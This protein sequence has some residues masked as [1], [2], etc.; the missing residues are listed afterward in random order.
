MDVLG[1]IVNRR[2]ALWD[3]WSCRAFFVPGYVGPVCVRENIG[4][5]VGVLVRGKWDR[6][7]DGTCEC[8]T[9]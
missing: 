4:G 1:N 7:L 9:K 2:L 6:R 5:N 8:D 3:L